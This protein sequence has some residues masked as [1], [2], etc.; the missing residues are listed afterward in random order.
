MT[1]NW[2]LNSLILQETNLVGEMQEEEEERNLVAEEV[3][4]A[5]HQ[6]LVEAAVAE[7]EQMTAPAM[8]F[9]LVESI[10]VET[11]FGSEKNMLHPLV[12]ARPRLKLRDTAEAD[13]CV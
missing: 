10:H 8:N 13:V 3:V 1:E 12:V 2:M 11:R 7:V 5:A 9:Q 4:V 6:L